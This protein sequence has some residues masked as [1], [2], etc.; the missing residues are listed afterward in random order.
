MATG[1]VID[2]LSGVRTLKYAHTAAVTAGQVVVTSSGIVLVAINDVAINVASAYVYIGKTQLPKEAPLA[3]DLGDIVYWDASAGKVTKTS[4]GNTFCGICIEAAGSAATE[5]FIY[6]FPDVT[7]IGSMDESVIKVQIVNLTNDNIKHLRGTPK[8]LI[9]APG[10]TKSV[11]FIS[12]QLL[13]DAG[14]NV[15]TESADNLAIRYTDGSG[16][17]VSETVEMTGFIDQ[18]ADTLTNAIPK[19]DAI[20]A[21]AGILNQAVVLHN[22]GDGEFAGNAANDATVKVRI[23]YRIHDWS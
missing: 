3:I 6:L 16:V 5:A 15:L 19:K 1:K 14:T 18:A 20:V 4:N 21:A 13:L 12:A 7:N 17:I 9:A 11:E 23:A 8:V 2:S 22:T 10:A